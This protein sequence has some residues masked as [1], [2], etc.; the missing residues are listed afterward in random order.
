MP[1]VQVELLFACSGWKSACMVGVYPPKKPKFGSDSGPTSI[2]CV[3]GTGEMP[4]RLGWITVYW[5]LRV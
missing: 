4:H 2:W 1:V 5:V 3:P